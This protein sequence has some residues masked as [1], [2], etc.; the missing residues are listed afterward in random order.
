MYHNHL[1]AQAAMDLVAKMLHKYYNSFNAAEEEL[2]KEV[3]NDNPAAVKAYVQGCKDLII[4]NLY[5]RSIANS[6]LLR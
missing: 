1:G 4:C 6:P 5:W 3:D 2:Y